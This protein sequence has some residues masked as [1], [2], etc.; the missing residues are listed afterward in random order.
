MRK[1]KSSFITALIIIRVYPKNYVS[2]LLIVSI[3][4]I[5]DPLSYAPF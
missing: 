4:N 2:Y 3:Y 5:I 1:N